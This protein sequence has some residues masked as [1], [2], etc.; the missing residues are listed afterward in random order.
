MPY[1]Q[2][3]S[4]YGTL[5]KGVG[6]E[7][8]AYPVWFER[9]GL[10]PGALNVPLHGM[11]NKRRI[12]SRACLCDPGTLAKH[13]RRRLERVP[14]NVERPSLGKGVNVVLR[15]DGRR[16]LRQGAGWD[17]AWIGE[18]DAPVEN[19]AIGQ[20]NCLESEISPG[21]DGNDSIPR[22]GT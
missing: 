18:R 20:F 1:A 9:A 4:Q 13:G 17:V 10:T 14:D 22:V 3:L 6:G 21:L 5:V 12:R 2:S 19:V 8:K 11:M 15:V 16:G 7:G